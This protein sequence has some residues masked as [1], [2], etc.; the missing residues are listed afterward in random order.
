MSETLCELCG[1]PVRLIASKADME[2]IAIGAPPGPKPKPQTRCQDCI[3]RLVVI[4]LDVKKFLGERWRL[5]EGLRYARWAVLD[6]PNEGEFLWQ[7]IYDE[8]E[9]FAE[10]PDQMFIIT[11]CGKRQV[12]LFFFDTFKQ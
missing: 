10:E 11:V 9:C 2:A 7:G 3:K 1:K 8:L 5:E 6:I 4:D 12:I